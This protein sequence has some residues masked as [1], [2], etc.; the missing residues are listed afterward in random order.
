ARRG[1]PA[2]PPQAE[3][4]AGARTIATLQ[5]GDRVDLLVDGQAVHHL[6]YAADRTDRV[7]H[8]IDLIRQDRT[9]Q[10]D[11]AR[12]GGDRH[13]ARVRTDA[14][15]RRT[16]PRLEDVVGHLLGAETGPG[17]G[18]GTPD[19][20]PEITAADIDRAIQLRPQVDQAI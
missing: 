6:A 11:A 17:L 5:P 9:V 19:P 14:A 4:A 8:R 7:Q 15:Q 20:V 2:L 10:L 18:N 3:R 12:P 16:N 1:R 13:R